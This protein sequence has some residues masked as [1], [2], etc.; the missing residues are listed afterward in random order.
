MREREQDPIR[1]AI[2]QAAGNHFRNDAAKC[3]SERKKLDGRTRF[4]PQTLIHSS[5]LRLG[6]LISMLGVVEDQRNTKKELSLLDAHYE[7]P[8]VHRFYDDALKR[9]Q[10]HHMTTAEISLERIRGMNT[11]ALYELRSNQKN[12]DKQP[13]EVRVVVEVALAL[14]E[15]SRRRKGHRSTRLD[16]GN[17]SGPRSEMWSTDP[18]TATVEKVYRLLGLP[19]GIDTLSAPKFSRAFAYGASRSH[20]MDEYGLDVRFDFH[21]ASYDG[22]LS[23]GLVRLIPSSVDVVAKAKRSLVK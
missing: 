20:H 21:G 11:L 1:T 18:A 7:S 19:Y 17:D 16:P 22:A 2:I 12:W 6:A 8:V 13:A 14:A 23:E 3:R 15:A 9:A 10:D 5:F 4:N